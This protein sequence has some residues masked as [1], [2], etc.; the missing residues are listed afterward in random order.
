MA[1]VAYFFTKSKTKFFM[2]LRYWH[3]VVNQIDTNALV[4]VGYKL[5]KQVVAVKK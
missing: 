2:A 4:N 3:F 1:A 5:V